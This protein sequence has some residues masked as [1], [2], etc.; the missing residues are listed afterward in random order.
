MHDGYDDARKLL[1]YAIEHRLRIGVAYHSLTDIFYVVHRELMRV[2]DMAAAQGQN[3]IP[4]EHASAAARETAWGVISSI[5]DYA[6]VIGGDGSDARIAVL[7]KKLH[8]DYEDDLV[9]AAARRMGAD[10]IVSDDAAFV[11]HS[12]LPALS[13][14]DA[15]TWI[16]S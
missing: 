1:V 2:N 12:P 10:L 8:D 5:L 14:K 11:A 6:E 16:A 9:Y 15:L 13:T 4:A 7:H 3:A